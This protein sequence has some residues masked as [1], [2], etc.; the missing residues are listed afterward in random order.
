M[1]INLSMKIKEEKEE[2]IDWKNNK[3]LQTVVWDL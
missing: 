3:V 2:I 1:N